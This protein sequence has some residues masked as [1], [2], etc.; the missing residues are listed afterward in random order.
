[1]LEALLDMFKSE[2]SLTQ[3]RNEGS[4]EQSL[5][6]MVL[7]SAFSSADASRLT[8]LVQSSAHNEESGI[9]REHEARR[10]AAVRC[11]QAVLR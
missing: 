3:L 10:A 9:R 6:S 2:S 4:V 8:A 5:A 7:V 1:M 11:V